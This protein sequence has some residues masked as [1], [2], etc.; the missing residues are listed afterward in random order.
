MKNIV[1]MEWYDK[2]ANLT[3]TAVTKFDTE[4][5]AFTFARHYIRQQ[6]ADGVEAIAAPIDL[7]CLKELVKSG[8]VN[9]EWY[10]P[11]K[12]EYCTID[13]LV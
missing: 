13:S 4:P 6:K 12:K 9:C 7:D 3:F 5:Q 2:S 11:I 8:V 1:I 10:D